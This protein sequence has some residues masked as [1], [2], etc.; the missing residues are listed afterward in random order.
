MNWIG[1]Y[2]ISVCCNIMNIAVRHTII[3]KRIL[4]RVFIY[5][6]RIPNLVLALDPPI[7]ILVYL[8]TYKTSPITVPLV[9]TVVVHIVF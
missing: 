5:M 8:P 3:K 9:S 7:E 2:M 6:S 1:T 4:E